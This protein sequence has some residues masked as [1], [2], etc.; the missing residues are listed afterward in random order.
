MT[1]KKAELFPA[2][3]FKAKPCKAVRR[4]LCGVA[5]SR[6]NYEI[7]YIVLLFAVNSKKNLCDFFGFHEFL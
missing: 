2:S 5:S 6:I 4:A 1:E 7:L 3:A